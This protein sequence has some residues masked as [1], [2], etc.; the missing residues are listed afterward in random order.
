MSVNGSI[1]LVTGASSGIGKATA[2]ALVDA[3][4]RVIAAARRRGRLEELVARHGDRMIA[5]EMDVRDRASVA[6]ALARLPDAWREIDIVVAAAGLAVGLD[7]L[8]DGDPDEWDRMLDTNVKGLLNTVHHTVP[9]MVDRGRGHFITIGSSAA[10]STY[11]KGAVYCASKAAA[12]RITAGLRLDV[13]GTGVRATIVHPSR[14][15]TEFHEVRFR[16]DRQRAQ[17]L[18]DEIRSLQPADVADAVLYALE[19]PDHVNVSDLLVTPT[20]QAAHG[21]IARNDHRAP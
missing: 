4:A 11:P 15:Q 16:G 13:L 8:Q 21:Q 12:E 3:G 2:A 5:R 10:R 9:G 20:D 7:P 14:T 17:G 1:A 19:Q 18:F 6:A